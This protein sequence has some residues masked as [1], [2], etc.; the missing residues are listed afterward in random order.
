MNIHKKIA[1]AHHEEETRWT[2]RDF[3]DRPLP[4]TLRRSKRIINRI[5]K[6]EAE[7]IAFKDEC[8]SDGA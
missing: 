3:R 2:S 5:A 1:N 6:R 4:A 8:N 7:R